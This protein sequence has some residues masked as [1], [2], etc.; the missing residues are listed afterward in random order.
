[1]IFGIFDYLKNIN[2]QR[3]STCDQEKALFLSVSS[4]LK[5]M[6][7]RSKSTAKLQQKSNN[8][9]NPKEKFKKT[10]I[11]Q[12]KAVILSQKCSNTKLLMLVYTTKMGI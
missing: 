12:K 5:T 10:C 9:N 3:P 1:M 4:D 2:H 8:P 7:I 11:Y 6:Q